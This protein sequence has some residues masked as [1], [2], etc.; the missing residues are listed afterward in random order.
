MRR[1]KWSEWQKK[2]VGTEQQEINPGSDG[3]S[4]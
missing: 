1:Q 2:K 4:S 3:N